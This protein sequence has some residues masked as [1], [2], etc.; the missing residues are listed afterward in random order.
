LIGLKIS[1]CGSFIANNIVTHS[2]AIIFFCL[3]AAYVVGFT[4][5]DALFV[6]ILYDLSVAFECVNRRLAA[7]KLKVQ[8]DHSQ[9]AM[10]GELKDII[11]DHIACIRS[12]RVSRLFLTHFHNA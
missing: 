10:E 12:G 6:T 8:Q 4:M 2:M 11:E 1:S 5:S 9:E 3:M 7:L